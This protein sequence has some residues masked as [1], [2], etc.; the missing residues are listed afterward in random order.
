MDSTEQFIIL[1]ETYLPQMAELYK[2]AFEQEP[3][4]DNWSNKEQLKEYIKEISCSFNSLNFG[5]FIN[6]KLSAMSIGM[7]RHWWEGT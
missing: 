7:I 4:N 2:N 5:L 1:D 6:S 3:W